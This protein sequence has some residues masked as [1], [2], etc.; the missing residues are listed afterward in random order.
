[1]TEYIPLIC[2]VIGCVVGVAGFF[3]GQ[4]KG[5]STNAYEQGQKDANIANEL[6]NINQKLDDVIKDTVSR[7]EF[8][9][10][11]QRQAVQDQRIIALEKNAFKKERDE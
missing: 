2:T 3:L 10:Y 11:K 4:K 1:M 7:E 9:E 6:R 8:A 5:L